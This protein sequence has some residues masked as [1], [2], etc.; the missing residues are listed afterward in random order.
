MT[1]PARCLSS[2]DAADLAA[3]FERTPGVNSASVNV[4]DTER[5]LAVIRVLPDAAPR[6][7]DAVELLHRLRDD[8]LPAAVGDTGARV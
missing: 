2:A 6:S 8:V 4:E 5:G 1:R 3:A 7:P